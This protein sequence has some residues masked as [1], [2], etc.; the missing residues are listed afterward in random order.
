M[1]VS[2]FHV[3]LF[4]LKKYLFKLNGTFMLLPGM[5]LLDGL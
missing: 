4:G 3:Y 1:G 5:G 2:N